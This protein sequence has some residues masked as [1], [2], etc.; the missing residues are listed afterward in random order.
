[1]QPRTVLN[2]C[3][4]VFLRSKRLELLKFFS[5]TDSNNFV[6][7]IVGVVKGA[8]GM[9]GSID[10]V[11]IVDRFIVIDG[12]IDGTTVSNKTNFGECSPSLVPK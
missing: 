2:P 11:A 3:P 7:W 12:I 8:P 9:E 6:S 5:D 4:V 1:M 10:G